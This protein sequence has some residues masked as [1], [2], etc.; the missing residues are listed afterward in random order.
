M[1][2]LSQEKSMGEY[3][4]SCRPEKKNIYLFPLGILRLSSYWRG[5]DDGV[6]KRGWRG[7]RKVGWR[8]WRGLYPPRQWVRQREQNRGWQGGENRKWRGGKKREWRGGEK[9]GDEVAEKLWWRGSQLIGTVNMKVTY[10]YWQSRFVLMHAHS[11]VF[12]HKN[13]AA[14]GSNYIFSPS[15]YTYLFKYVFFHVFLNWCS[16]EQ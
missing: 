13:H 16:N 3:F 5:S 2:L 10:D 4:K 7:G 11:Y 15:V 14:R 6:E 8:W 12:L 1:Q 9:W